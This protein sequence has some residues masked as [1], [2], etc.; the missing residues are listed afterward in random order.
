MTERNIFLVRHAEAVQQRE[1]KCYLGQ[2]NPGLSSL[3]LQ[4]AK[5]LGVVFSDQNVR[6]VYSS[7]LQ[8]AALTAKMI[9][10]KKLGQ[11][12]IMKDLREINLGKWEG[13]SFKEIQ[14]TNYDE[15]EQRGKDIANHR[16]PEGESFADLARRVVP[17]FARIVES[18]D[19]D[20][21]IVAHAGVNRVILCHLLQLPLQQLFSIKQDYAGINIIKKNKSHY[22]VQCVNN[23][24]SIH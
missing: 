10:G 11:P 20:I 3:G 23:R 2:S 8:R 24:F 22:T 14:S 13:K 15:F 7:D 1:I 18:T 16:P 12:V 17:A 9:G 4:Q 6:S 21:V 5:Q 19:G